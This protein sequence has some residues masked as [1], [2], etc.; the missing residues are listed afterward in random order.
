MLIGG[1]PE[2]EKLQGLI[3]ARGLAANIT[4][5]GELP[6]AE[7]LELMQ[8]TKV[9]LHTSS[10]EG[11]GVVFLEALAAG[12]QVISFCKPMKQEIEQWHIVNSKEEMKQKALEVLQENHTFHNPLF[13][14]L[15][16][17]TANAVADL[18]I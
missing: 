6:H 16:T 7:V 3:A 5:T 12:C 4:L 13:P 8:R 18:F 1:G 10:Y 14:F 11:F 2:K 17:D 15:I 9:F